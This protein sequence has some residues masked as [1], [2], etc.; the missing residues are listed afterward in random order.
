[1]SVMLN[2]SVKKK[3]DHF[4]REIFAHPHRKSI[5]RPMRHCLSTQRCDEIQFFIL[6]VMRAE[7]GEWSAGKRVQ[8]GMMMIWDDDD[9]F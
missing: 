4:Q 5:S 1:M 2:E 9:E 6:D 8:G 7:W 3:S